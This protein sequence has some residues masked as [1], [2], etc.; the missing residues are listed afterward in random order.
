MNSPDKEAKAAPAA[1]RKSRKGILSQTGHGFLVALLGKRGTG[2]TQIAVEAI[3]LNC[4]LYRPALYVTAMDVFLWIRKTFADEAACELDAI[5]EFMS[6]ALLVIDELGERGETT[7][8]DRLLMYVIDARYRA[9][10]DTILIANMTDEAFRE[11][12]GP[13]ISDRIRECGG[14]ITCDW[15]SFRVTP[16][17]PAT[18]GPARPAVAEIPGPEV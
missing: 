16:P 1:W 18:A 5:A 8:E 7:W 9:M 12:L 2:K 4:R 15:T 6:P 13:S 10:Q 11:Q 3:L 17:S 14:R